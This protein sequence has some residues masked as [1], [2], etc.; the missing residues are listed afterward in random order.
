MEIGG[1]RNSESKFSEKPRS[2]SNGLKDDVAIINRRLPC[3]QCVRNHYD[4]QR[5][6][7]ILWAADG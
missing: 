6:K 3:G 2:V 4:K 1:T 5:W 7:Q